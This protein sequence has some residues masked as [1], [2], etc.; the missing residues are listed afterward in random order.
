MGMK[1]VLVASTALAG[2]ACTTSA[3]ADELGKGGRPRQEC[4]DKANPCP[5]VK[6]EPV[7]QPAYP[8]GPPSKL[9]DADLDKIREGVLKENIGTMLNPGEIGAVQNRKLDA[10]GAA[11]YPGYAGQA[12]P[13]ARRLDIG[14]RRGPEQG[15]QD[16]WLAQNVPSP[17][18]FEDT[19]GNPW[20][21]VSIAY[22]PRIYSVNGQGCGQNTEPKMVSEDRPTFITVSPCKFWTWGTFT[23]QL[24]GINVPVVFVAGSGN[25][26]SRK[27]VDVPVVVHVDGLSPTGKP[28]RKYRGKAPPRKQPESGPSSAYQAFLNGTPPSGAMRVGTS[29]GSS[30]AWLYEGSLYL[31]APYRVITPAYEA[32]ASANNN[33]VF[34]FHR[35]TSRVLAA[36]SDG[37]ERVISIGN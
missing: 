22:D 18:S 33:N 27:Y 9:P 25:L 1:I 7:D 34:R 28:P 35:A 17:I 6:A 10:Q 11:A 3:Y 30:T 20:P 16:L 19:Y 13:S 21:I 12:L 37:S 26:E 2:M 8:F 31:V 5:V 15:P 4:G 14:Y 24:Q 23:V 32:I 29:D 36:A